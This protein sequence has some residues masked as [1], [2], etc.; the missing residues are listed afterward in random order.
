MSVCGPIPAAGAGSVAAPELNV[1]LVVVDALRP[2]HL[3][4]YGYGRTTSPNLDAVARDGV[5]FQTAIAQSN[6]TLPA[7]A[8]LMTS[9]YPSEHGA[10]RP[11]AASGWAKRLERGEFQPDPEGRLSA[12]Q[13]TLAEHLRRQGWQTAGIVSGGICRSAFGFGQGFSEFIDEGSNLEVLNRWILPWLR[14]HRQRRFF[15]YIH[16]GDVHAPYDAGPDF[17]RLWDPG[18]N[19]PMDGSREALRCIRDREVRATRR[20]IRHLA[21]LYDA[22]IAYTDAHLGEIFVA[23]KRQ[24]LWD[25]TIVL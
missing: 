14:A 11:P 4:C 17:S 19:G 2:D 12:G 24:G 15:L 3:G 8:S 13:L 10:I 7:L 20:D 18:Y 5:V 23:L 25:R 9:R 16:A 6:W 1:V 22:E 21:A